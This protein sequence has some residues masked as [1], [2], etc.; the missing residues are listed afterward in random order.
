[1]DN[2]NKEIRNAKNIIS[3]I[4]TA[5]LRNK[6]ITAAKL[7]SHTVQLTS[8]TP[9]CYAAVPLYLYCKALVAAMS[10]E[11]YILIPVFL[12]LSNILYTPTASL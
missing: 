1:M 10:H 7:H 3:T 12:I 11:I 9:V 2:E 4:Y 8:V 6:L 5:D